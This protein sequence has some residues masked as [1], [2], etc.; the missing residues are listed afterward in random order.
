M[1]VVAGGLDTA[2][3]PQVTNPARWRCP[4]LTFARKVRPHP[5]LSPF[6]QRHVHGAMAAKPSVFKTKY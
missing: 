3:E 4:K 1:R 6:L 2:A 5:T